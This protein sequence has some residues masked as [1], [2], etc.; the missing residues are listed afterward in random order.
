MLEPALAADETWEEAV[1]EHQAGRASIWLG[2]DCTLLT[3]ANGDTLHVWLGGGSL[4]GLMMLRPW[5]ENHAREMGFKRLT[6][7]G[8]RGWSR[9]LK[10]H[11]WKG[12]DMLEKHIGR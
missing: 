9:L 10:R 8:R 4:K 11:G 6:L 7:R 12:E 3:Q 5:A 2:P 1:K